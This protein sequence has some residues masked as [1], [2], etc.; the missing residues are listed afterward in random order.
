MF[1]MHAVQNFPREGVVYNLIFNYT[2][3]KSIN[4]PMRYPEQVGSTWSEPNVSLE[5]AHA[6]GATSCL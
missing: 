1:I 4:V 2:D 3:G 6:G 5:E